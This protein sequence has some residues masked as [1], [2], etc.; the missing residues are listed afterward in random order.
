VLDILNRDPR[1]ELW[2]TTSD[3]A[4][5]S[6]S[7]FASAGLTGRH[8][9]PASARR[10]KFE[11]YINTDFWNMTWLRAGPVAFTCF[12]AW[13]QVRAR[14]ADGIAPVVSSFDRLMFP[15]RDRL[16]HYAEAGLVDPDSAVAA[17]I[18]Y[19]K[20]DCLV[21]GSLDRT[22]SRNVWASTRP[23]R[24]SCMRRPGLRTRR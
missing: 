8:V 14:C 24:P 17:L 7:I 23:C 12:T 9:S 4:W 18:G 15:N 6:A 3:Q 1:I 16:G 11:A 13:P 2:C 21:D 20:V 19:P 22:P 10:M 5:D